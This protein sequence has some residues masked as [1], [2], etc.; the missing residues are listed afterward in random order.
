MQLVELK[1]EAGAVL[2]Q[3]KSYADIYRFVC[4]EGRGR[5]TMGRPPWFWV[6]VSSCWKETKGRFGD[7]DGPLRRLR[8]A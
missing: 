8:P 2:Q 7:G 1:D 5:P 3:G 6:C 4:G